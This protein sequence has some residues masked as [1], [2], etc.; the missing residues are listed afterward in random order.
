[1]SW[2]W[3]SSILL[4]R[5]LCGPAGK[6]L[7]ARVHEAR[8]SLVERLDAPHEIPPSPLALKGIALTRT[9]NR[10]VLHHSAGSLDPSPS[11][12]VSQ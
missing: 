4:S 8:L 1:M 10:I 3:R 9:M 12:E 6:P 7:C 5:A 2:W 11:D